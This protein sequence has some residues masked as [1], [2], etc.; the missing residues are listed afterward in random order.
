MF[1]VDI[2]SGLPERLDKAKLRPTQLFAKTERAAIIDSV[3]THAL[4]SPMVNAD[5][6]KPNSEIGNL[7]KKLIGDIAES[8]KNTRSESSSD[9]EQ[10]HVDVEDGAH[11]LTHL[12]TYKEKIS[13]SFEKFESIMSNLSESNEN[14]MAY[15]L[16]QKDGSTTMTDMTQRHVFGSELHAVLNRSVAQSLVTVG[17]TAGIQ[18]GTVAVLQKFYS[19]NPSEIPDP[20]MDEARTELGPDASNSEVVERA[21]DNFV[22]PGST[23]LD[24]ET[25]STST[26]YAAEAG[27]GGFRGIVVPMADSMNETDARA[28]KV[29]S[30]IENASRAEEPEATAKERAT[31]AMGNAWKAQLKANAMSGA[32]ASVI[33]TA[34]GSPSATGALIEVAKT[35]G[36]STIAA[37]SNVAADGVRKAA[38][39]GDSEAKSQTIKAGTRV[40]FRALSQVAKTGVSYG[41]SAGAGELNTRSIAGD[42]I[43]AAIQ[44][45]GSGSMKEG[46]GAAFQN[47]TASHLP[48]N[49]VAVLAAGTAIGGI[50]DFVRDLNSIENIDDLDEPTRDTLEDLTTRLGEIL[51]DVYNVNKTQFESADFDMQHAA[52]VTDMRT[53]I[54]SSAN[55]SDV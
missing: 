47:L 24:E 38:Y 19:D 46:L 51:V 34:S 41:Q 43:K 55:F 27:V 25:A 53:R 18:V 23:Y 37:F 35:M 28:A 7:A 16:R 36:F 6:A 20:V 45:V 40:A 42:A 50:A 9:G 21:I 15:K 31:K 11:E 3:R 8:L 44:S 29:E 26:I 4:I 49:E 22:V 14:F 39:D 52:F 10:R 12:K 2:E 48:P 13:K 54:D 1:P 17:V 5:P 32:I 33:S 30:S